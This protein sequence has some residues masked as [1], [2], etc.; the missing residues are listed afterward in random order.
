M[1]FIKPRYW[2]ATNFN[3]FPYILLPLSLLI[4]MLAMLKNALTK[5]NFFKVP[6][7][8]IGNIYLGGTGKTPL[9]HYISAFL[10]DKLKKKNSYC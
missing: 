10:N 1:K 7:I 3:I 4:L 8:C 5:E 9:C 2:D 6:I